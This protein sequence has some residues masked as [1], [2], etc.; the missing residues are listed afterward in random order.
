MRLTTKLFLLCAIGYMGLANA[1]EFELIAFCAKVTKANIKSCSNAKIEFDFDQCLD[2][3]ETTPNVNVTCDGAV[4]KA[5]T[6]FANYRFEAQ[7]KKQ[8]DG[9]GEVTWSQA[10]PVMTWKKEVAKAAAP[11]KTEAARTP[12]QEA[13]GAIAVT[14]FIDFRY[15]GYTTDTSGVDETASSGFLLEDAAIYFNYKKSDL[16]VTVDLPYSRQ[17]DTVSV[18]DDGGDDSSFTIGGGNASFGFANTKAQAFAKYAITS[19]INIVFGQFD[20]LYG[21]ELNDSKDRVFA[22]A[23]L[24]YGQTLPFV[25]SGLYLEKVWDKITAKI[26][27]ANPADKDTLGSDTTDHSIET[28]IALG[29]SSDWIR[30][31]LG[32]LARNKSDLAGDDAQRSLTDVL[33][34]FTF[35]DFNID[36]QYSMVSDP[37]KNVLTSDATDIENAGTGLEALATYQATERIKVAARYEV[38]TDD[39]A[40]TGYEKA[41]SAAGSIAYKVNDNL[42]AKAEHYTIDLSDET[43]D[44]D[45]YS[46]VSA[47]VVF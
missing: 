26:L 39:P 29:Y 41:S 4:L 40:A 46:T 16:Q 44:A 32:Y 3:P 7:F 20:T 12:T 33:L 27:F 11:D 37:Q 17:G 35:G 9:W 1:Q 42:T 24:A 34:G 43:D 6:S 18:T 47:V 19:D 2:K 25:H 28:G 15:T 22:N 10:G 36:F 38:I 31:Q 13:A 30:G 23:G 21:L 5:R 45:T 8:D 14:G